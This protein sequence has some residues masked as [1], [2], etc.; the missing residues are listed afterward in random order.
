MNSN[1]LFVNDVSKRYGRSDSSKYAVRNLSYSFTDGFYALLGP[2]GAG[3]S[4]LM[5]II[6]GVL[7]PTRGTVLYNNEDTVKLGE[8]YRSVLGYM[9]QQ[10]SLYPRFTGMDFLRYMCSLKKITKG[11]SEEISRTASAVN[12]TE[13]LYQKISTYSGGMKQRLL[14]AAALL[15]EPRILIL[16][17]PTAGLDPKER[18]HLRNAL[19]ELSDRSIVIMS[20]H[21]VQDIDVDDNRV[22]LMDRG[23]IVASGTVKEL[24]EKLSPGSSIEEAYISIIENETDL[25]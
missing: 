17:E 2:N 22:I 19:K 7:S 16:D 23:G 6:A 25:L 18:V 8:R 15:G 13:H 3:K 14:A 9:P 12:M 20:T 21:V 10:Q 24:T 4:T 1:E 5:K 11:I